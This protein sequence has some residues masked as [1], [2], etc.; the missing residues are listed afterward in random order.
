LAARLNQAAHVA[1]DGTVNLRWLLRTIVSDLSS[2]LSK[3]LLLVNAYE[4]VLVRVG[5]RVA[6]PPTTKCDFEPTRYS[7]YVQALLRQARELAAR[8]G[9]ARVDE[10]NL[11]LVLVADARQDRTRS[12]EL[13]IEGYRLNRL[14]EWLNRLPPDEE[15]SAVAGE[16]P[17]DEIIPFMEKRI[18][19][20]SSAINEAY[21]PILR[22]RL[23]LGQED[24]LAGVFL[25]VG[26]PG[27]GK[28]YLAKLM[29]QALYGHD[30]DN[31]EAHLVVIECG[32]Y[33]DSHAVTDFIGAP[34]GYVGS[35]KGILRDGLREKY[36]CVIVFDE[37]EKMNPDI[38]SAFLTMFNDGVFRDNEGARFTLKDCV[39]VLTA[40]AGIEQAEEFRKKT[41]RGEHTAA[42]ALVEDAKAELAETEV[43]VKVQGGPREVLDPDE[44]WANE[45]Y[46]DT[47]RA[48]LLAAVRKH[49]GP[50]MFSRCDELIAFNGLRHADYV[51]IAAN[52]VDALVAHIRDKTGVEL[53]YDMEVP[54]ALAS[55]TSQKVET[56][57]RDMNR[58]ARKFVLDKAFA[59]LKLR[60]IR[61]QLKL[62]SSYQ[63][64]PVMRGGLRKRVLEG[65]QLVE[66]ASPKPADE[67]DI[68][69]GREQIVGSASRGGAPVRAQ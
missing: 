21:R 55:L 12:S 66:G 57:A 29:A 1:K 18:I 62:A 54:E 30:P 37:A 51:R 9:Q 44:F 68:A 61:D 69:R 41:L 26:P 13:C 19:N 52:A 27:V 42:L 28:S 39:V 50:A 36:P 22:V 67:E 10:G 4:E 40:N 3:G 63:L 53:W 17:I 2:P 47:Y 38:W 43:Q 45:D 8:N 34:H 5:G 15:P 11:A 16:I 24:M 56:S 6:L 60:S 20:Q 35:D 49:F 32:R 7:K 25:F 58:L 65:F 14:E 33:K 31:P 23:G 59:E 46:R 64:K 48:I